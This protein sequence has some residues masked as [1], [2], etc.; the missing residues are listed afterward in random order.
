MQGNDFVQSVMYTRGV[1]CSSCH[2][3]HGTR[4]NADL[5]KPARDSVPDVPRAEVAERSAHGDHRAAHAS[6]CRIR[7]AASASAA[8]CRRSS[9]RSATSWCAA[10]PS[11]SSPPSDDRDLEDAEPVHELPHGQVER[12]GERDAPQLAG[13][14]AVARRR[15]KRRR[16]ERKGRKG[17]PKGLRYV[18]LARPT[19]ATAPAPAAPAP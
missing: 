2:D 7:P 12:L 16:K 13:I 19:L 3:V 6:P 5:I 8:T 18:R 1:T 10:T 17:S 15:L 11:G 14:L 9:R 4:H